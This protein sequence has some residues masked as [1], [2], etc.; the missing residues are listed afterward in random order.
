MSHPAKL[1]V[2]IAILLGCSSDSATENEIESLVIA[3]RSLA[4]EH[5]YA[6]ARNAYEKALATDPL[7]AETHYELGN[8]NARLGRLDEAVQA[9]TAA[10]T[11]DSTH[12][13]A[14]HNLAVVEA[15][16]GR[17]PRAVELLEQLPEHAPA[18]K[19]LALFYNKQGRYDLAENTLQ[20]VLGM[21]AEH[22]EVR[23][24]LGQLFLRQGRYAEARLE[25]HRALELD[26]KQ[27]ESHR[28]LGLLYLAEKRYE[29]ALIAFRQV[30]EHDP[31]LIEAHYNLGSALS[32]LQRESE[33][34]AAIER[35]ETL[36]THAAQIARLRRQLDTQ[37]D[38]LATRMELAYHYRQLDKEDDAL[39]HYRSAQDAHPKDLKVLIQLSGLLLKRGATKEALKICRR[40]IE[41]HPDDARISALLFNLGYIHMRNKQ[42]TDARTAFEHVLRFEPSSAKAWNNIANIQLALGETSAAQ[43]ALLSAIAADP[44]IAEA[45]YNLGSLYLQSHQLDKARQAYL[46][47]IDVDSTLARAYYALATIY[48]Q[49][50]A[51][52]DAV[53]AYRAFIAKWQGDPDFLR[54]ARQQLTLLSNP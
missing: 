45:H 2:L 42:Y 47:A 24:Q 44:K 12:D 27:A 29:E 48:Q 15:D 16:R 26:S 39:I 31:Y 53:Q 9:Y 8:L 23:Q 46:A 33:A 3:G 37:P 21:D 6:E 10:V 14:R 22:L 32:A 41:Q 34:Q 19:T 25:L 43:Q 50:D 5:R 13:S 7:D 36:S 54:Q 30:V 11:T 18:L 49:Q 20:S 51:N 4:E 17:L 38:H 52:A 40:G 28:L 1:S 35:F